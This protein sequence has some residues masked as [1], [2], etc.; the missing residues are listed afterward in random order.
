MAGAKQCIEELKTKLENALNEKNM[1]TDLLGKI[2]S[3]TGVKRLHL[4][5]GKQH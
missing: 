4:A 3:K 2:E 5:L 1:V